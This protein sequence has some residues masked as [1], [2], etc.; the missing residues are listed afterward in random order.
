MA[1]LGGGFPR[2]ADICK[3]N[4]DAFDIENDLGRT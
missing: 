1:R 4:F 3:L 2:S